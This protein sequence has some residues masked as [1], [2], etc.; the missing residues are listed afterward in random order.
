M[1][2]QIASLIDMSVLG[3]VAFAM[4]IAGVGLWLAAAWCT[5]GFVPQM[6]LLATTLVEASRSPGPQPA[7]ESPGPRDLHRRRGR[8]RGFEDA[9]NDEVPAAIGR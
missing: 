4:G 1:P 6:P 9:V 7:I 5:Y 2:T 3:G 8:G